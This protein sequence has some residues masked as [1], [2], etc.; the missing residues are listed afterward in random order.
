M[1]P[2]KTMMATPLTVIPAISAAVM[3]GD[4]VD[5]VLVV[6][7]LLESTYLGHGF[8]RINHSRTIVL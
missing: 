2:P 6:D 1:I 5:M 7:S 8:F 3:D 4:V